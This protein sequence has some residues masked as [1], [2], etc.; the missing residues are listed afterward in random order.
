MNFLELHK[1]SIDTL[2]FWQEEYQSIIIPALERRYKTEVIRE[3]YIEDYVFIGNSKKILI[4]WKKRQR[5]LSN[6][7]LERDYGRKSVKK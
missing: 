1:N 4:K 5:P 3:F 2:G 6:E 7:E